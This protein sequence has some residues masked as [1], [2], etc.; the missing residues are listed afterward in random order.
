[1]LEE[2]RRLEAALVN[3]DPTGIDGGLESLVPDDFLEFGASGRVWNAASIREVILEPPRALELLAFDVVELTEDVVLVTYQ[4]TEPD[5]RTNRSSVWVRRDGRWQMRFHQGTPIPDQR[6][7]VSS[8]QLA[9][10]QP[11]RT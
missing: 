10:F 5:R 11:Q 9:R 6:P 1:V 4:V 2:L 7:P 8:A 3:R